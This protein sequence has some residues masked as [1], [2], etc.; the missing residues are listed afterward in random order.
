MHIYVNKKEHYDVLPEEIA[1]TNAMNTS[2]MVAMVRT[3]KLKAEIKTHL[4]VSQTDLE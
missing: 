1:A 3:M 4:T 2:A